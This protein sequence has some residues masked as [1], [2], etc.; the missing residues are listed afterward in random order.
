MIGDLLINFKVQNM[1]NTGMA[2]VSWK[3]EREEESGVLS[4]IK[5]EKVA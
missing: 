2:R 4:T 5:I 3:L 1:N